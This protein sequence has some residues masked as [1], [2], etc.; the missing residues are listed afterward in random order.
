MQEELALLKKRDE[1]LTKERNQQGQ[2]NARKVEFGGTEGPNRRASM[3]W[4][5][6]LMEAEEFKR[7]KK[8]MELEE[9]KRKK[10]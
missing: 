4:E 3:I 7:R 1:V 5:E 10:D 6:Q 9:A 8:D 2:E